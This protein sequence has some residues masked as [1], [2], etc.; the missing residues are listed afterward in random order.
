MQVIARAVWG[1]PRLPT[2][3][4]DTI[5]IETIL[6]SNATV[7]WERV[8]SW[9]HAEN[10]VN[11]PPDQPPSE[12]ASLHWLTDKAMYQGHLRG[13]IRLPTDVVSGFT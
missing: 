1:K 10:D 7:D 12:P 5:L 2:E 9:L 6:T 3:I 11:P 4:T 13:K 8:R